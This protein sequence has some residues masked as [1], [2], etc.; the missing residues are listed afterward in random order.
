MWDCLS[1]KRV[2]LLTIQPK[3]SATNKEWDQNASKLLATIPRH[4]IHDLWILQT[5]GAPRP[6]A[7]LNKSP[8][9]QLTEPWRRSLLFSE[10]YDKYCRIFAQLKKL[11]KN[12]NSTNFKGTLWAFSWVPARQSQSKF[13]GFSRVFLTEGHLKLKDFIFV[14]LTEKR[15]LIWKVFMETL[16]SFVACVWR[17]SK[18]ISQ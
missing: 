18:S 10:K 6:K 11:N 8:K 14:Y 1:S 9:D 2:G 12:T 17:K 4:F 15:K 3:N 5:D 16:K 7:E 13:W